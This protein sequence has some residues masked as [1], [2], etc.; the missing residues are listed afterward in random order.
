MLKSKLAEQSRYRFFIF[1]GTHFHFSK[2]IPSIIIQNS[3]AKAHRGRKKGGRRGS[4][5]QIKPSFFENQKRQE[6]KNRKLVD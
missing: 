5:K 2:N 4:E 1:F 6:K 3:K